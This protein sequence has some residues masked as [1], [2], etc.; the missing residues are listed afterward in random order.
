[1]AQTFEQAVQAI[2]LSTP[3]GLSRLKQLKAL[4]D[5]TETAMFNSAAGGGVTRYKINTGQTQIEVESS[6][7]ESLRKQWLSLQALYNEMYG[8]Y[9]G[10]N[11]MV[12][13]DSGAI[14]R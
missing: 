11:V 13:R 8:I 7:V 5:A 9:S 1:M 4:L 2:T 6:N 3:S 12:M 10:S 14:G